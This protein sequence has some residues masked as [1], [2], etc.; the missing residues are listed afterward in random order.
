MVKE[1]QRYGETGGWGFASFRGDNRLE[2]TLT[3]E[4]QAACFSCH[5]KRKAQDSVFS[6]FRK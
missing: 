1:S 6:E 4:R 5:A 2:G 3:A